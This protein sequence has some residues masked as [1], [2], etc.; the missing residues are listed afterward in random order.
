MGAGG[1]Y[2]LLPPGFKGDI[3]PGYHVVRPS[4]FGNWLVF[5]TFL[6]DGSTKPGVDSVKKNLRIYRLADAAKTYKLRLPPNIPVK[7][8]WSVIVYD[9]QTRSMV[10]ADQK[11][12]SVSSQ[13]KV[14]RTGFRGGLLA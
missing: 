1:K 8:F 2:L 14:N 13:D 4:T 3:P 9:N 10:Q 12:P 5:R 11:A 7:N 6:V